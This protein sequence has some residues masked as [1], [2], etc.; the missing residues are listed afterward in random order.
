MRRA[1]VLLPLLAALAAGCGTTGHGATGLPGEGLGTS[2]AQAP[3]IRQPS[4]RRYLAAAR[5]ERLPNQF[6][7]N[8]QCRK[9]GR[10]STAGSC[11]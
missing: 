7:Q 2:G 5:S 11:G 6:R 1:R 9:R 3:T 10:E 8:H 4:L